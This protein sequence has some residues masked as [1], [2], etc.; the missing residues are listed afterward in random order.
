MTLTATKMSAAEF[1][2]LPED[3]KRTRYE[4]VNGEVIVSPSPNLDHS[5]TN[6][7]L[8]LLLGNHIEQH[9]L[10]LLF[11][12]VDTYFTPDDV[13]RPDIFYFTQARTDVIGEDFVE[14]PPDL[15]IEILSPSNS[16]SDRTEKFELYRKCGVPHYW[17]VDPMAHTIEAFELR[18]ARY[19]L[20]GSGKSGDTVR[21][22]PFPDLDIVVST[23][24]WAK[25]Q[26]KS[27]RKK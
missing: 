6:T 14:A 27:K 21:L 23:L 24:W 10:G 2:A 7:R 13:R 4:L 16:R 15:C 9:R 17:I 25:S 26:A 19:E 1:L 22:P 3:P 11:G 5:Y 8:T 18:G 20:A 12:D